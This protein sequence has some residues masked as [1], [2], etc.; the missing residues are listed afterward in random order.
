MVDVF[1]VAIL[2]GLVHMSTVR[3]VAGP[4]ATAFVLMVLFTMFSALSIDSR[5]FKEKR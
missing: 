4:G 3:V 5:V 2:T 1:V